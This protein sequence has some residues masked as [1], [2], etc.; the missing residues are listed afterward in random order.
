MIGGYEPYNINRSRSYA[1]KLSLCLYLVC[2]M[3]VIK[4]SDVMLNKEQM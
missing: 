4:F 2:K 3:S 1:V